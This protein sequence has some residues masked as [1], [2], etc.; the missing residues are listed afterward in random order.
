MRTNWQWL[1][2]IS[3]LLA[4]SEAR[5]AKLIAVLPLDVTNTEKQ[6]SDPSYAWIV[7]MR[8]GDT[9]D[10]WGIGRSYAVRCVR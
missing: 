7:D 10:N 8:D 2:L 6:P 9:S 1:A 4:A 5:A 3:V